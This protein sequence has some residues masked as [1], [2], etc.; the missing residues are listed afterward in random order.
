MIN[1]KHVVS[2][3]AAKHHEDVFFVEVK[4]GSTGSN[5]N[6]L[7]A[8]AMK[9]TWSPVTMIGYEVKV[10]KSDYRQDNKWPNYLGLCHELYFVCPDESVIGK[11]EIHEQ[12]GLM[13][14]T[15]KGDKLRTIKKAPR[16]AL[17]PLPTHLMIYLLMSRTRPVADMWEANES[18]LRRVQREATAPLHREISELK[19]NTGSAERWAPL[20]RELE[21]RHGLKAWE[22]HTLSAIVERLKSQKELEHQEATL[23]RLKDR[24]V[25]VLTRILEQANNIGSKI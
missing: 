25:D 11:A 7:D 24:T 17:D 8:W 15:K 1:A 14:L 16:R 22:A 10:S 3:L 13:Y 2:L 12:V 9:R 5:T 19:R 23:T 20:I 18:E 4:D 21:D 6:R